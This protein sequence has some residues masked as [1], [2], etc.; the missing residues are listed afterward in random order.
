MKQN[1]KDNKRERHIFVK[2]VD[3]A[4]IL[5]SKLCLLNKLWV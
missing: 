3:F 4:V 1:E 5:P 2:L